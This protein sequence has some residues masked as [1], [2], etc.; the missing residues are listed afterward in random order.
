MRPV[1]DF[2]RFFSLKQIISMDNFLLFSFCH[3]LANTITY[4]D[5][6]HI[7][8]PFSD[9]FIDNEFTEKH[10]VLLIGTFE[11]HHGLNIP[12]EFLD[13]RLTIREFI[14]KVAKL[15]A[16]SPEEFKLHLDNILEV[17]KN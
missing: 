12:D 15:P 17:K 14:E 7:D 10:L 11:L 4:W 13:Y 6:T 1:I 16:L 9:L 3:F 8:H 2:Q 5:E